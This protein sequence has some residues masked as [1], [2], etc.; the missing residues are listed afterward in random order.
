MWLGANWYFRPRGFEPH[1]Y[2]VLGVRRFKRYL[3]TGGD[4]YARRMGWHPILDRAGGQQEALSK[5]EKR[6][7]VAECAHVL[8]FMFFMVVCAALFVGEL[9]APA[10]L[11]AIFNV[12]FNA[13]PIMVQRYNRQRVLRLSARCTARKGESRA[14]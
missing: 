12:P 1:V 13:Y 5:F 2:E 11:L 7:R 14:G 9:Y 4:I 8:T 6:T 10:F 3:P